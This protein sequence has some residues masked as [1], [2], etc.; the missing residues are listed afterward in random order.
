MIKVHKSINTPQSLQTKTKY[1]G[2]D[3][4]RQLSLD[5]YKKCY[6]CER[7]LGTDYNIEHLKSQANNPSLKYDWNNLLMACSYCN[8]KKSNGYDDIINPILMD[9]ELLI[10]QEVVYENNKPQFLFTYNR[11]DNN[12]SVSITLELL[13]K[14]YN[15]KNNNMRTHREE[16]FFNIIY[17]KYRLFCKKVQA[18][19]QEPN[20]ENINKICED[21]KIES[22]ILGL[23][24]WIIAS[25]ER[26]LQTFEKYIRWNR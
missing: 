1:D 5:Q 13:N 18:Y 17:S 6:L 24:Y 21:L 23:K 8:N 16:E 25:D 22:E 12:R 19:L 26:L 10:R 4:R 3:V 14:I 2:E 15:G 11:N 7:L 20:A 9:V